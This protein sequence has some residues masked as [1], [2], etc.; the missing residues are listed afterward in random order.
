MARILLCTLNARYIHASAGLRCL[1]ANMAELQGDARIVE[2][3]V[4]QPAREIAEALLREEPRIIGFG[5]YIWNTV[6]THEVISIIRKVRPDIRIVLGGPEVSH[7]PEAQPIVAAADCVIA[8]EADLEFYSLCKK[9]LAS[10]KDI[11]ARIQARL[12][13]LG[14]VALPYRFYS[15]EDIAHRVIYVEASRGCP[16]TCEF[17]LSSLDIPVRQFGLD[18][19]LGELDLLYARGARTFKFVDR[20]FNLNVRTSLS[21]LQFFLDR[22]VPGL[23]VH[24]E[25]VPDR[26]PPQLRDAVA[27]FPRGSLQ[28]EIGVQ[29][30]NPEVSALISRRQDVAKLVDNLDFLRRHTEAYLHVDLIAGLPGEDLESFGRGFD[31]LVALN[32]QEIQVGILKKLRG[33]PIVRHEARFAMHFSDEPPYEILQNQ[34]LSFLELQRIGRFARYWDLIANSGNFLKTRHLL[35]TGIESAF[36]GFMEFSDWLFGVVGRR[37]SISLKSLV[38]HVAVFL[39]TQR[40]LGLDAFGSDLTEDYMRGGRDDVPLF[41]R[42]Y[43]P[44]CGVQGRAKRRGPQVALKRQQRTAF[45]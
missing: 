13:D 36:Q 10:E 29:T 35:W 14:Q 1:Y 25:M 34:D 27:R 19:V 5:V 9:F 21:I 8:G 38:E 40:G 11:P 20:T 42:T 44:S 17:C 7:E 15:D 4:V 37:A 24:F 12:P 45:G 31:Q 41:L 28:L 39:Q 30:L 16:F 26:F 22:M 32:P 2:F 33:T 23:F 18:S 6:R 3:E 43:V